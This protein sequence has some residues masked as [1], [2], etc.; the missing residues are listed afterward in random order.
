MKAVFLTVQHF[1]S[2][3]NGRFVLIRSDNT[4]VV[5]YINLQGGAKSPKLCYLDWELWQLAIQNN[6]VLQ[7][8][9]I[10]G[11]YNVLADQ[12]N[13]VKVQPTEWSLDKSVVRQT[14][15]VWG[16]PLIDLFASWENRQ[17]QI[18]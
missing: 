8:A 17:T 15:Q 6:I 10:M 18:F 16:A 3:L 13:R 2:H 11:K 14:F 7:S 9:H 1:L 4:S 12:L 5:Q